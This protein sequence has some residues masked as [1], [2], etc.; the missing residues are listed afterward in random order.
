VQKALFKISS[1]VINSHDLESLLLKIKIELGTI[2][3]TTNFYVALYNKEKDTFSLPFFSDQKDNLSD[4]PAGKTMTK[5]VVE[6]QK[7]LLANI[8]IKNELAKQGKLEFKGT[9]SKVWL[10]VPLKVDGE[11]TGVLAVQ[12]YDDENAFNESDMKLLEF[13]SDQIGLSIQIKQ[14]EDELKEALQKAEEAD[15]LKTSFL[16]NMSHEIR[17]PMNGIL[18]FTQLLKEED[19]SGDERQQFLSIIEKSGNRMLNI[20]NDLIDVSKV[21]AGL[22]DVNITDVDLFEVTN[23]LYTFFIREVEQKGIKLKLFHP[24]NQGSF[25]IQ[26]DGEK[27]YAILTNLIKN[28]IKYSEKGTIEF[29]YFEN[30]NGEI[31]FLVKD[32]GIGIPEEKKKDVF[33]RFVQ[34]NNTTDPFTEGSGLGLSITKAY[35]ELLGGK[36]WFDSTENVGTEFCFTIPGQY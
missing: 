36:I 28:A 3:D 27:I 1:S 35:V 26:T 20:I 30:T 25:M 15:R 19:L 21:D 14:K 10:G 7:S 9:L 12:S 4:L 22:M 17:T 23:Y 5:Y 16:A 29:G 11:I 18:G 2:I 34:L 8:E 33:S 32:T 31:E 6:T 24:K 13:V